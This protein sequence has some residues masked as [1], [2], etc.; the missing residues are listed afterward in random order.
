MPSDVNTVFI[1]EGKADDRTVKE[2]STVLG[3]AEAIWPSNLA[4]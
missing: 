1:Q 2:A 4:F 3:L